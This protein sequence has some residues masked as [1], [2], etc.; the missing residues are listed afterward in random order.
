MKNNCGPYACQLHHR[1]SI[2]CI[3]P[4]YM[5]LK[6]ISESK[7]DFQPIETVLKDFSIDEKLR[8]RRRA[9]TK[10]NTEHKR[11][12]ASEQLRKNEGDENLLFLTETLEHPKPERRVYSAGHTEDLPGKLI[13]KEG[14]ELSDDQDVNNVYDA[15]GIIWDFYYSLFGRNSIDNKG[16][17]MIQSV[18]YDQNYANAFWDG[19][20]M[21]YGDG[22][23]KIFASFTYDLDVTGHEL[24]HGVIQYECDLEY[25]DQ[26]GAINESLADVFGIMIKQRALNQDVKTSN[27]LI[28][29]NILIG[30]KYAI[31]SLKAPGTAYVNHPILGTD[32]QPSHMT[33]YQND[34]NDDGGVHLN[35]GILNHAFYI[36]SYDVGG[37]AWEKV[38][39]VWY[40]VM[41]NP[42][43]LKSNA[44]FRDFKKATAKESLRLFGPRNTV[45]LA[46][47]NAWKNVGV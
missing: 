2:N 12:L 39:R 31:R 24:T 18:H 15:A 47:R 40:N 9:Y 35:S 45:T 16:L 19:K 21:A 32:P 38:G 26:S 42:L 6:L 11:V 5:R 7:E 33:K 8:S 23:G 1:H 44:N 28:G 34:P 25:R 4:P 41:C 22:D 27:W 13:R 17:K 36:A 20:Q 10:L 3:I 30:D 29:E 43:L 14:G 46:I 37:F